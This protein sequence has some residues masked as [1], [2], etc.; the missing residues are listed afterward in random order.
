MVEKDANSLGAA[1]H[2]RNDGLQAD[3]R[4][5]RPVRAAFYVPYV[6]HVRGR[7]TPV[8]RWQVR[9]G[10][11]R[12]QECAPDYPVVAAWSGFLLSVGA[13]A[14]ALGMAIH[15]ETLAAQQHAPRPERIY[16]CATGVEMPAFEPCKEIKGRRDI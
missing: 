8:A 7:Q 4:V 12:P 13:G 6:P 14:F 11:V 15:H 2:D 9:Q 10:R 3:R 1:L 16:Y 5:S